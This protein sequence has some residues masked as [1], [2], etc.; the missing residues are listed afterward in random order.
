MAGTEASLCRRMR[1][2]LLPELALAV[3]ALAA[4][5]WV[6]YQTRGITFWS[7]DWGFIAVFLRRYAA[8][9]A[10][11]PNARLEPRALGRLEAPRDG[12][13]ATPWQVRVD[14]AAA[15]QRCGG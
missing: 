14:P 4:T 1:R 3:V 5:A 8:T 11:E 10:A 7:D 2:A 6:A 12:D 15:V 13:P 9:F